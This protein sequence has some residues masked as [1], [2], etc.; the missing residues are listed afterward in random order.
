M[1]TIKRI[2]TLDA[3]QAVIKKHRLKRDRTGNYHLTDAMF[4]EA[5]AIDI[6][7]GEVIPTREQLE[8]DSYIEVYSNR[9]TNLN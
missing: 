8:P 2:V 5:Q 4:A 6:A 3:M 9:K 1:A 7:N